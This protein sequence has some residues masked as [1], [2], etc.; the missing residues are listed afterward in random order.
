LEFRQ[1]KGDKYIKDWLS[2]IGAKGSTKGIYIDCLRSYTEFLN[3]TPE[4]IIVESEEDIRSGKLM[5]ERKIFKELRKF[6]E[7]LEESDI[8]PMKIK[9]KLTGVRSFLAL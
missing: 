1:L 3:K 6:R 2:G 7:Y 8:A 9:A 5:R 4:Q